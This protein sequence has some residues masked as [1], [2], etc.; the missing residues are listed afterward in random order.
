MIWRHMKP[1]SRWAT[2][3]VKGSPTEP[4]PV[5]PPNRSDVKNKYR[6]KDIA[7]VKSMA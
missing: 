5:P 7:Y 6:L 3:A 2:A 1:S 4:A